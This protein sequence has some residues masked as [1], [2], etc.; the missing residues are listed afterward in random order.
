MI[1]KDE[2]LRYVPSQWTRVHPNCYYEA[3]KA[4]SLKVAEVAMSNGDQYED[5]Y[6]RRLIDDPQFE[7]GL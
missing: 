5:I 3:L 6:W 7:L 1:M 4:V 2:M